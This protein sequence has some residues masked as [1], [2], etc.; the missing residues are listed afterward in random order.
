MVS[1]ANLKAKA[2]TSF[3]FALMDNTTERFLNPNRHLY[4]KKTFCSMEIINQ[5]FD[6]SVNL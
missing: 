6:L 2:I 5:P 4:Y 3:L 1:L